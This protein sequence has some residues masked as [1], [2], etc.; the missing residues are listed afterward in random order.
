MNLAIPVNHLLLAIVFHAGSRNDPK[1]QEGLAHFMEHMPFKGTANF[2]ESKALSAFI[3]SHGGKL[4]AYTGCEKIAFI[5]RVPRRFADVGIHALNELTSNALFRKKDFTK[6]RG[7]IIGEIVEEEADAQYFALET[8]HRYLF[9]D[10]PF[11]HRPL[12]ARGTVSSMRARDATA[13]FET[14]IRCG[15]FS[16][17]AIGGGNDKRILA[18]L[19]RVFGSR[20]IEKTPP[21]SPVLFSSAEPEHFLESEQKF[22]TSCTC[23]GVRVF[24]PSDQ[25]RMAAL[26]ILSDMLARDLS[27]P[28]YLALREP[29][30]GRG[31]LYE[32]E[33]S[34]VGNSQAGIVSFEAVAEKKNIPAVRNKFLETLLFTAADADRFKVTKTAI[35]RGFDL[36][37]LL[38][39]DI[40]NH[41]NFDV[42]EG[43]IMP[44]TRRQDLQNIN[45]VTHEDVK[46]L[47]RTY[48]MPEHFSSV[49][50]EGTA[51]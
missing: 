26:N 44:Q 11:A 5:V 35:V 24:P 8:L 12:G 42:F 3:E 47:V 51:I 2:P 39:M 20:H 14:H 41:A 22:A 6:E 10:T 37:E 17:F 19:D 38:L 33:F 16:L 9:R 36:A 30:R 4:G 25:K 45:A 34:Y 1:G 31:L 7:V 48:L 18:K 43:G 23:M 49:N 40:F 21:A 46:D 27:S 13:F 15:A 28:L 32:L 29:K 50:I